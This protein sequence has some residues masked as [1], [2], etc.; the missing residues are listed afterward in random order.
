MYM[1][2]NSVSLSALPRRINSTADFIIITHVNANAFNAA[3]QPPV[4]LGRSKCLRL[5]ATFIYKMFL[6]ARRVL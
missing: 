2:I 5:F 4:V 3:P 1:H 6:C